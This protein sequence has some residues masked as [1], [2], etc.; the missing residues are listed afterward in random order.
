MHCLHESASCSHLPP[1]NQKLIFTDEDREVINQSPTLAKKTQLREKLF[2]SVSMRMESGDEKHRE[3]LH[4]ISYT[5]LL[6]SP[7]WPVPAPCSPPFHPGLGA[8]TAVSQ[9]Y[10]SLLTAMQ[11]FPS[12]KHSFHAAL[13]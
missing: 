1:Q 10:S 9:C 8:S 4:L 3:K 13:H 7:S 12:L 5:P 6:S 2:N 11:D